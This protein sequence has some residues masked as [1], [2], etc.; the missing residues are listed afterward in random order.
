MMPQGAGP[1]AD[2]I[3]QKAPDA[4]SWGITQAAASDAPSGGL[5]QEQAALADAGLDHM[6]D[7]GIMHPDEAAQHKEDLTQMTMGSGQDLGSPNDFAKKLSLSLGMVRNIPELQDAKK[8]IQNLEDRIPSQILP[9]G[10]FSRALYAVSDKYSGGDLSKNAP[11][12]LTADEE[13]KLR[14][15][16]QGQRNALGKE[17]ASSGVGIAK[18]LNSGLGG[19][20]GQ[21]LHDMN[22]NRA[23]ATAA[24]DPI[25]KT[26]IPRVDGAQKILSLMDRAE[27]GDYK[28]NQAMLGQL[29]AEISRLETG[30]Q[31]PGLHVS[32]KTE[33]ESSAA[34]LRAILDKLTNTVSG[35]SLKDQFAQ[36][37]GMVKELQNSYKNQINNRLDFLNSGSLDVQKPVF[38][39]KKQ[40]LEKQYG[41]Q[42]QPK[43]AA[44]PYS[45]PSAR[46]LSFDEWKAQQGAK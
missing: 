44:I 21:R 37:R 16:A 23:N 2:Q 9:N 45:A 14:Q 6:V 19:V 30:S 46:P 8:G 24:N 42:G 39:A 25:L 4:G 22:I 7:Q 28:S 11:S 43:T 10:N 33:M 38:Q 18:G 35:V 34:Q 27:R 26:Y 15:Y 13:N 40:A 36:A 3:K 20:A 5:S 29:N 32:E 1:M 12:G 41:P 31:A 17:I